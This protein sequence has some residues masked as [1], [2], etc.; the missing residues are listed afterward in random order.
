[1]SSTNLVFLWILNVGFLFASDLNPITNMLGNLDLRVDQ[2]KLR[3]AAD[4][5]RSELQKINEQIE[6]VLVDIRKKS[7]KSKNLDGKKMKYI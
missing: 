1:M 5:D 3:R 6:A 2:S 4:F 7:R